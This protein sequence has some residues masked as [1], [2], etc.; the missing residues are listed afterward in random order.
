MRYEPRDKV[1]KRFVVALC[2]LEATASGRGKL[3]I[4]VI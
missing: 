2:R 1:K 4:V 3:S